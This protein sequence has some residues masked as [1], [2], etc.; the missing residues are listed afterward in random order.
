MIFPTLQPMCVMHC[1]CL[2]SIFPSMMALPLSSSSSNVWSLSWRLAAKPSVWSAS[3]NQLIRNCY[4]LFALT[5][6][7]LVNVVTVGKIYLPERIRRSCSVVSWSVLSF[8][9]VLQVV[10]VWS[11]QKPK[12]WWLMVRLSLM[13][14]SE[15]I[16]NLYSSRTIDR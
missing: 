5:Y 4:F 9:W 12:K 2:T 16:E 11:P 8:L 1:S 13:H 15:F 14:F 10:M 6:R 7:L 3:G